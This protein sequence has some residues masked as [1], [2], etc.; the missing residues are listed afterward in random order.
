[1]MGSLQIVA[2]NVFMLR[3]CRLEMIAEWSVGAAVV[4]TAFAGAAWAKY[5]STAQIPRTQP[6]AGRWQKSMGSDSKESMG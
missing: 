6:A 2:R 1:M 5:A 3:G 4:R